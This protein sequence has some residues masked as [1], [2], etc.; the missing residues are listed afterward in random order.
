MKRNTRNCTLI[1]TLIVTLFCAFAAQAAIDPPSSFAETASARTN[2]S[3]TVTWDNE[4]ADYDSIMVYIND[5][6]TAQLTGTLE[7]YSATGLT[8]GTTYTV[9]A[10]A[11]SAGTTANTDTLSIALY[12]PMNEGPR[13]SSVIEA[14]MP[15]HRAD[16]WPLSLNTTI[17][18]STDAGLDSS[19]VIVPFD[20]TG[21]LFDISGHADSTIV[22]AYF[23]G[24]V[25]DGPFKVV[26]VDSLDI[27]TP[28][29]KYK[30]IS[31][32]GP[33]AHGYVV[34]D[35]LTNNGN[36]TTITNGY[37]I[38]RRSGSIGGF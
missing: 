28:G 15:L 8:P 23:Y 31:W 32:G 34:F 25:C 2:T 3:F 38:M 26:L 17:T 11:D 12:Y 30:S 20:D 4:S 22:R 21:L 18:I 29:R 33:K 24:G 7:T 6:W 35:G 19:T 5:T 9:Y 14:L 16:S 13:Y 36:A 10:T 1:C 27:T 37:W